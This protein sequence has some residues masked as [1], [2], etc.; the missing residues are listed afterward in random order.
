MSCFGVTGEK[1]RKDIL[2]HLGKN[3]KNCVINNYF[4]DTLRYIER[5]QRNWRFLSTEGKRFVGTWTYMQ[6]GEVNYSFSITFFSDGTYVSPR[7]FNDDGIF[8]IKDGLLVLTAN[9]VSVGTEVYSYS[10][11]DNDTTLSLNDG[12]VFSKQ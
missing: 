6:I 9:D 7:Y 10:F 8:E 3:E 2:F 4:G 12:W 1:G 5:M 11:S